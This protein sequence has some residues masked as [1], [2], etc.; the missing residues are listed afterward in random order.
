MLLG[1]MSF[2]VPVTILDLVTR[3][4]SLAAATLVPFVGE[5]AI[6]LLVAR[7]RRSDAAAL[8]LWMLAGIFLLGP[9]FIWVAVMPFGG[10]F[11]LPMRLGT[12]VG[13]RASD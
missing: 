4:F 8:A 12:R 5:L 6:Y 7:R 1:G 13:S 2:W 3:E 11:A 10:G 9:L